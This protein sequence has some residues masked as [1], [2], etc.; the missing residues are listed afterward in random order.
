MINFRRRHISQKRIPQARTPR[1]K[2]F[3]FVRCG[4]YENMVIMGFEKEL[5]ERRET[6]GIILTK[7]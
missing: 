3:F 1:R 7:G 6:F 5:A 2:G 4:S